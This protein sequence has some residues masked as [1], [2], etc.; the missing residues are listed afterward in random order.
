MLLHPC[1]SEF[2]GR[3]GN[4]PPASDAWSGLLIADMFQESLEEQ[5]TQAVILAPREKSHSLEDNHSRK[6]SPWVMSEM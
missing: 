6:G 3:G 1:Q 4:Q 5:I 2:G